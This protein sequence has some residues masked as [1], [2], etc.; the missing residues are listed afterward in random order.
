VGGFVFKTKQ[1]NT[2]L[3]LEGDWWAAICLFSYAVE[4]SFA[5]L[6]LTTATGALSL[7]GSVQLTMLGHGL[8]QGELLRAI[9]FIGLLS[10][11]SGLLILQLPALNH[12][13]H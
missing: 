2:P 13:P 3:K 11:V 6:K 5:H 8:A 9:Q 7:F 12:P 4:F 10:A 1:L